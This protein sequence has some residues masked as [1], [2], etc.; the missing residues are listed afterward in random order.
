[1]SVKFI[2][3]NN[4]ASFQLGNLVTF[5]GTAANEVSKV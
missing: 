1:M 5:K 3:P 2:A 4:F